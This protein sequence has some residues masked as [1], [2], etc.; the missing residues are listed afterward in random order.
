MLRDTPPW[1]KQYAR[2]AQTRKTKSIPKIRHW[3]YFNRINTV[4]FFSKNQ[5]QPGA[6]S[7][8]QQPV[9]ADLAARQQGKTLPNESSGVHVPR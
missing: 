8:S 3:F 4:W 2:I 5:T 9:R 6:Q 1:W 7:G